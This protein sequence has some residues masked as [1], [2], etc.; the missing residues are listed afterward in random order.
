[1]VPCGPVPSQAPVPVPLQLLPIQSA[2]IAGTARRHTTA[3]ASNIDAYF[4]FTNL[5]FGMTPRPSS[6]CT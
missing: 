1:V 3:I 5:Y 4:I 6:N 2:D